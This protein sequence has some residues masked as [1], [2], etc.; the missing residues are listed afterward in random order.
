MKIIRTRHLEGGK[1]VQ[2]QDGRVIY[3]GRALNW[4]L[5]KPVPDYRTPPSSEDK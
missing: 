1:I 3:R 4:P 2:T 5:S